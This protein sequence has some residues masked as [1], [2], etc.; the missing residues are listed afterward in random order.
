MPDSILRTT[1]NLSER[2]I[3][4]RFLP[5]KAIDILDE[6]CAKKAIESDVINRLDELGGELSKISKEREELTAGS[7]L[8]DS[9]YAR[10]AELRTME[11]RM[12][13][14]F[15]ELSKKRDDICLN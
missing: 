12:Q 7:E 2:Y 1:V 9:V 8:D 5:D 13:E 6:A 10:L 15:E 4:D 14:E 11:L 3:T